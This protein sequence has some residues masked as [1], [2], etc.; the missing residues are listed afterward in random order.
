MES[1]GRGSCREQRVCWESYVGLGDIVEESSGKA[2]LDVRLMGVRMETKV[3]CMDEYCVD[4]GLVVVR[5]Q[6]YDSGAWVYVHP[7][8]RPPLWGQS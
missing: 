8:T 4:V 7:S 1:D 3:C 5:G 6:C 2:P